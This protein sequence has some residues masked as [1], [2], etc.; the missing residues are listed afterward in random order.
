M[1]ESGAKHYQ[2]SVN[3]K[4]ILSMARLVPLL[5]DIIKKENIDI[6]HARSRVP[7]WIAYFACRKSR[8]IFITTCH[9]YYTKHPFSYVMGWGKR[10]IV[11]SNIIARHMIEDFS[12]PHERIRLIPRSVDLDKFKYLSP[13]KKRGREFNVGIIGR[14]TPLKGHLYFVKAMAKVAR[15]IPYLKIWIVGDASASRQAYKEEI[16]VLVK[17]IGLTNCTEFLGTQKISRNSSH[18]DLLVLPLQP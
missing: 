9:G 15:A 6:V 3:K 16:Q 12:V 2:L 1:E 13:D 7:A 5:L 17:R 11:L 18:L 14:I 8:A 4:S 10:V